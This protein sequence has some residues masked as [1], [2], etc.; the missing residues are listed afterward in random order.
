MPRVTDPFG[1]FESLASDYFKQL[2]AGFSITASL[3]CDEL[4]NTV[5]PVGSSKGLGNQTDLA[6]LIAMR[7]QAQVI[8][9]TGKTLR[10]DAYSFPKRADLAV[11]TT[12][13]ISLEV[14]KDRKL[15]ISK[16]GYQG[17]LIELQTAGYQ[18][19]HI[20]YGITGVKDL[21]IGNALDAL[22]LSSIRRS[23]VERISAE[24][25]VSP[26][27]VHIEDLYVGLVA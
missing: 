9:T 21:V 17:T 11:L 6:L 5:S 10:A 4:G 18:R 7:R 22:V 13:A 2:V 16:S 24:L 19:M 20:E 12:R 3:V 1:G 23:G 26:T 15:I 25:G 8:V 27:I 14:P